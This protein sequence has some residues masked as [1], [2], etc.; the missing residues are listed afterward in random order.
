MMYGMPIFFG[1]MMLFLPSGLCLYMVVSSTFS[2]AQSF[3]VRRI[4][5]NEDSLNKTSGN[6]DDKVIDVQ[7]TSK[8]RRAAKRREK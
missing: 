4:L 2:M 6:K 8:D 3:Y 7:G 5:A 1:A